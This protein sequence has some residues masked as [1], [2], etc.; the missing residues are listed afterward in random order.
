MGTALVAPGSFE[1]A[2]QGR[3]F[4]TNRRPET[5]RELPKFGQF[6]ALELYKQVGFR[7][8]QKN[9]MYRNYTEAM[10][11]L[12]ELLKQFGRLVMAVIQANH[13]GADDWVAGRIAEIQNKLPP[14][15][16]H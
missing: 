2:V 10:G 8:G 3:V 13:S 15:A 5:V 11:K 16:F 9:D 12:D 4:P 1:V 14:V 7:C 6:V